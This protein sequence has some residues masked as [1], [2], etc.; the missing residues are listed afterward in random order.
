MT[1]SSS[2][3]NAQPVNRPT[4]SSHTTT[5]QHSSISSENRL[6]QEIL[7]FSRK[8]GPEP[9]PP[10]VYK[11]PIVQKVVTS[12][13]SVVCCEVGKPNQDHLPDSERVVMVVGAT[14]VGKTTLINGMANYFFGVEW[15]DN[16]RFKLVTHDDEGGKGQAKS[17]TK[18]I[19]S[20]HF[21]RQRGANVPY[22]LTIIDTPGFGDTHGLEKDRRTM[23]QIRALFMNPDGIIQLDGIGFVVQSSQGRLTATQRYIFDSILSIF[24][25]DVEDIIFM[26]TTF[27]DVHKQPVLD[28]V[29]KA[30]IKYRKAFKFNN[31][32]LFIDNAEVGNFDEMFWKMCMTRFRDFFNHVDQVHSK[33]LQQT[34]GVLWE[35]EQLNNY[36]EKISQQMQLGLTKINELHQDERAVKDH[37]AE[38]LASKDFT[39]K[40][41][42]QKQRKIDLQGKGIYTTNCFKCSYTCH[43]NCRYPNDKDK[44]NCCAMKNGFCTVCPEKCKWDQHKNMPYRYKWYEVTETRTIDELQRRYNIATSGKFKVEAL[45][46]SL[47]N[48]LK[49][50][51]QY[52]I[53]L[54]HQIKESLQRLSEI[55]LRPNPLSVV[56]YINTLIEGEKQQGKDRY[57]ER[58]QVLHEVRREAVLMSSM[59]EEQFE[60]LM[61]AD[62]RTIFHSLQKP[63][64]EQQRQPPPQQKGVLSQAAS[65]IR[66]YWSGN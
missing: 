38:I 65:T 4:P 48:D 30:E 19:T 29:K 57:R 15:K 58:I 61:K 54:M 23:E 13:K 9:G 26:M 24:R 32:A 55:A 66:G 1:L 43:D 6:A 10:Q 33:S 47:D 51:H 56:D 35:R 16:F 52:V 46:A 45:M 53:Q 49:K 20:Y 18:H 39:Y 12:D 8:V 2:T 3:K 62:H 22:G 36:V 44:I 7:R 25:K 37:E 5:I 31:S 11:L 50:M 64:A 42:V 34:R 60:E 17:K 27:A 63:I 59:T 14:G 21:P 40:V 28:A 41:K